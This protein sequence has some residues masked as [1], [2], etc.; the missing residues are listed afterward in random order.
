MHTIHNIHQE[1]VVVSKYVCDQDNS[2]NYLI[3]VPGC[4]PEHVQT[5]V[6]ARQRGR[7]CSN[8]RTVWT[9]RVE[10]QT[11]HQITTHKS[12][13]IYFSSNIVVPP[14]YDHSTMTTQ[15]KQGL[16]HVKVEAHASTKPERCGSIDEAGAP[17]CDDKKQRAKRKR[18]HPA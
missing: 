7:I 12:I 5:T 4:T 1:A 8:G 13:R 14:F 18:G 10:A 16:V 17:D 15:C 6:L 2:Y 3:A 9:L 11:F